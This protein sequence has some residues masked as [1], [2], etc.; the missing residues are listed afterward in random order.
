MIRLEAVRRLQVLLLTP[1]G[2]MKGKTMG[3]LN[4]THFNGPFPSRPK[5]LF[6]SEVKYKAIPFDMKMVFYPHANETHFHKKG[7]ALGL[8]LKVRVFAARKWPITSIIYTVFS[9]TAR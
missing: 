5:P 1:E 9:V 8:V 6:H 3:M 4:N 2:I 7:F